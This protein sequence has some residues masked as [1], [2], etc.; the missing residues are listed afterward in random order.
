MA[1]YNYNNY[2]DPVGSQSN[3]T[4]PQGYTYANAANQS[5]SNAQYGSTNS[6]Y[7]TGYNQNY[8]TTYGSQ[9][10]GTNAQQQSTATTSNAA[11]TLSSLSNQDYAQA[12]SG[13]NRSS[14]NNNNITSQYDSSMY[15][16]QTYSSNA[17]N[18]LTNRSQANNSPLY[19]TQAAGN[20]TFGRLSLPDQ[21]QSSSNTFANTQTYPSTNSNASTKTYRN[22]PSSAGYKNAYQPQQT[23][24]QHQPQRYNSP[25]HAV[26]AQQ[27][28]HHKQNSRT[29][30]HAASPQMTS[31]S[32]SH[33]S[34]SQRHQSASVEPSPTTVDPSQVYDWRAEAEKKARI[35]AER[36][37]K[38]EA[39]AAVKKAEEDAR[40]AEEEARKAEEERVATEQRDR[41]EGE[42]KAR[43]AEEKKKA[44]QAKKNE[45]RK[46]AREEQKQSKTAATALQQ[47]AASSSAGGL[48]AAMMGD[49]PPANDEEAEMRAMF[50]KMREFNQKNPAML[51]KLWEEERK[52]HA[53]AQENPQPPA[54]PAVTAAASASAPTVG[55]AVAQQA[56][57]PTASSS[58]APAQA[59]PTAQ[60]GN[61]LWPPHKKGSLAEAASTW[62]GNLAYNKTNGL[63][64]SKENILKILDTN[65][66]YVQLCE[67][68]EKTGV[69]FERS[70]LAKELLKAVPDGL[71]NQPGKNGTPANNNVALQ[72]N[73][74]AS[75]PADTPGKKRGRPKK[76]GPTTYSVPKSGRP[77]SGP[78]SYSTPSFTSL[79]A[80]A[81]EV[82]AMHATPSYQPTVSAS[83]QTPIGGPVQPAIGQD[84]TFFDSGPV[85]IDDDAT[86][87][88]QPEIKPEEKP[89]EPPPPPKDKEEAARKRGFADLVDLTAQDSDDDEGPPKKVFIPSSGPPSGTAPTVPSSNFT[90]PVPFQQ[91]AHQNMQPPRQN[92]SPGQGGMPPS[93]PPRPTW[94]TPSWVQ[95]TQP[96]SPAPPPP[97]ARPKGPTE[98]QKQHERMRGK[99]LV[100]PIMRDRVARKS[101]Y[102]SRT[103]ARDVLLAT[104]RHPDM[105]PLNNHLN[106]MQKLLGDH[107][108]VIDGAGNK[109]DLATIRW[110]IID[111]GDPSAEAKAR[112][113][114]PSSRGADFKEGDEAD[115]ESEGDISR[116]KERELS[117][118]PIVPLPKRRR[119]K[120]DPVTKELL[121]LSD[122]EGDT[123]REDS[124]APGNYVSVSELK[125]K[126]QDA[127][128]SRGP[129]KSE[130][131]DASNTDI[132]SSPRQHRGT[133]SRRG[134]TASNLPVDSPSSMSGAIGYAQFRQLDGNG[135]P[136]KKKGRPVG[137]RKS[138]HSREAQGLTPKKSGAYTAKSGPSGSRLRQSA[139]KD[140]LVEP[141]Y[142]VYHCRWRDCTAELDNLEK[143]KKHALKFHG[144]ANDEGDFECLWKNCRSAGL[145]VDANGKAR[146]GDEG[147]ASFETIEHWLKHVN[148][149][150]FEEIAQTL[151]DGPRGGT[152]SDSGVADQH[153]D[154]EAY[155]S[156]A[157]GR[158]VTPV[159]V[160]LA[161]RQ[162]EEAPMQPKQE[163]SMSPP[164][165][166]PGR[167]PKHASAFGTAIGSSKAEQEAAA[168]LKKL[169]DQKRREGFSMGLESSRLVNEKRR[170][171]FLDDE[172]FEDVIDDTEP[173]M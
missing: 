165:K 9:Q 105:R 113:K 3:Q 144:V 66:S 52:Q 48:M 92:L 124:D 109:S 172:D 133:P 91:F 117:A 46:K 85:I 40:K 29:S 83:L 56:Q 28:G 67:A 110:D 136:I 122:H 16:G 151:G 34:Q 173:E 153:T 62:L 39:E 45:A 37:R 36:R 157:Y 143:L 162:Q 57:R 169:E 35:E 150:H 108:G 170:K 137:W 18:S 96:Q 43:E 147:V 73:G 138:V 129:R 106:G 65:P 75:S 27:Q 24:Q 49:G 127:G 80:A 26:Q 140:E 166:P 69:R 78:V 125:R 17:Y 77:S 12:S 123:A 94:Q 100:E 107:G 64:I 7:Q 148:K 132:N 159:I 68:V 58:I 102:D 163:G 30:N 90:K 61:S 154:S 145:H 2:Y 21:S 101:K 112:A 118:R 25:L 149:A 50:K 134:S 130:A 19:A 146:Q 126:S 76:P 93:G 51:A 55:Q 119:R 160:P 95:Q 121:P 15:G 47:M 103:I 8:G 171:G 54:Q 99:M 168:E 41:E 23:Q 38:M 13:G 87:S 82:N 139:T 53:A 98:E 79:A 155:L 135:N 164:T 152:V 84:N 22:A 114:R 74:A 156:D 33:L 4:Q 116:F 63:T 120:R 5:A 10:Y 81:R 88:A 6:S 142:Q 104:G 20:S 60:Q 111:P 14:N 11:S 59:S 141:H 89:Q 1:P 72:V 42:R 158:S 32:A 44:A 71:R 97:Q 86:G 167:P 131:R 128:P 31:Q 161:E 115:D 70:L